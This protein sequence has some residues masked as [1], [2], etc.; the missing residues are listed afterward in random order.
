MAQIDVFSFAGSVT[1]L[2]LA[3]GLLIAYGVNR[4]L[5][6]F[7][8]WAASFGLL[9]IAMAT[10][11]LR[12]DGPS[13]W[14][15]CVSWACFYAAACLI[16]F[17][18]YR[19]GAMRTNPWLRILAGAVLYVGI[20]SALI[21]RE[22]PP[23]MWFLLGPVPTMV[24]MAWSIIPV[25]RTGAWGYALALSAGIAVIGIRALWF[26]NDLVQMGPIRRPSLRGALIPGGAPPE[27]LPV[28][29]RPG[30]GSAP[31]PEALLDFRP[32]LSGRPPVEQPLTIALITIGALLALAAILVLRDVL[33]SVARMR[34]RSTTDYMTGLLNRATFDERARELLDSTPDQ[35]VCVVLFDIDHFKKINDTCGHAMGDRV[36]ARLGRLVGEMTL[37]R[38]VAGRIGGEEFAVVLGGADLT[39]VRLFAEAIRT[40]LAA[41]T[42]GPDLTWPVTVS[43]GVAQRLPGE[44]LNELMA[45]AD[46]A[47][48][49]AKSDGRD[50]VVMAP[51]PAEARPR[52]M[53][54]RL[55]IGI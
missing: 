43:A 14:I 4:N 21:G 23:H 38:S 42:F 55:G 40:G 15:K 2:L 10:V 34:E 39:M 25:L 17:G 20:A 1:A 30:P 35:A 44:P 29:P 46:E 24:L 50:R 22:A 27:R 11:T 31:G 33:A 16:A 7:R 3:A 5:T 32:P 28:G 19:E 26:A 9:A 13:Y 51:D 18:L 54:A 52:R 48:Y 41:E 37:L 36:I 53:R 47:L 49:T 8:W 6:A 12:F 45:R